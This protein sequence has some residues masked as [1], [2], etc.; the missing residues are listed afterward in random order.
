MT[1][2]KLERSNYIPLVIFG[3][4]ISFVFLR[5]WGLLGGYLHASPIIYFVL[6]VFLTI[7]L[8]DTVDSFF[9]PRI[10]NFH[11][12]WIYTIGKFFSLVLAFSA[13]VYI[14]LFSA[15]DR[16]LISKISNTPIQV[17]LPCT[18]RPNPPELEQEIRK[19]W[20]IHKLDS[21][22]DFCDREIDTSSGSDY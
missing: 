10:I 14:A 15:F 13:L 6:T 18:Y 22:D 11:N 2:L 1:V 9:R 20:K 3:S 7:K 5:K 17:L 21:I 12:S 4:V 8:S 16:L 19:V